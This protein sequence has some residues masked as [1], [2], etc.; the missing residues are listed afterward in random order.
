MNR[1][2]VLFF[3]IT[4]GIIFS[5]SA[6]KSFN[7]DD[8]LKNGNPENTDSVSTNISVFRY[9][10]YNSKDLEKFPNK[11]INSFI[12]TSA[13][14][15]ALN[16]SVGITE[17]MPLSVFGGRS[18]WNLYLIDGI[19]YNNP[20][21][22]QF[23][24]T[25][26]FSAIERVETSLGGFG[27]NYGNA[28][29]GVINIITKTGTDQFFGGGEVVSSSLT[30][31]YGF[32]FFNGYLGGPIIPGSKDYKFFLSVEKID[33]IDDNPRSI[34]LQ[35]PTANIDSEIL[36]SNESEVLRFTGKLNG[37]FGDFS[38]VFSAMGSFREARDYIHRY[39]K[40]NAIHNPRI[41]DEVVG[42]SLNINHDIDPTTK[43]GINFRYQSIYHQKGDG[44]WFDD[45]FAYG[46]SIKN[47]QIG[48]NL[49]LGD[50]S[51]FRTDTNGVFFDYGRV[52]DLY[53]KYKVNTIGCDLNFSK[54]INNLKLGFGGT[55]EQNTVRYYAINPIRIS[56]DKYNRSIEE[57]FYSS[58]WR[59]YGY[60]LTGEKEINSTSMRN[61]YNDEFEEAGAKKPLSASFYVDANYRLNR[62]RINAG[63]RYNYFDP[64][65]N[66]IKNPYKVLGD[67]GVLTEDD[68]EKAPTENY[69]S[70][71]LGMAFR[72]YNTTIFYS[73][74]GVY[75]KRPNLSSLYDSWNNI[76]DL[77]A[78]DGTGQKHGHLKSEKM[79]KF[80]IGINHSFCRKFDVELSY[81]YL[82]QMYLE[83]RSFQ[84]FIFGQGLTGYITNTNIDNGIVW[85]GPLVKLHYND[86]GF[87]DVNL[88]YA[89]IS[90]NSDDNSSTSSFVAAFRS[91]AI[92]QSIIISNLEKSLHVL[93]MNISI[94]FKKNEGPDLFEFKILE[95][96]NCNIIA[97]YISESNDFPA[98]ATNILA[99]STR[100]G[101]LTQYI[102]PN[103]RY[104]YC[105]VD[106]NI[107]RKIDIGGFNIIPYLWIQNLFNGQNYHTIYAST[108]KPD[109]SGFLSTTQGQ[110]EIAANGDSFASDYKALERNPSN[111]DIPRLIRLGLK[112]EF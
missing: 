99:G 56:F 89:Y 94:G 104:D 12:T 35:I 9:E 92:K 52:Y 31:D 103:K 63:L 11:G 18:Y 100:Y 62:L 60:D 6:N 13:G 26:P 96:T 102:N 59:Y 51:V 84:S 70:P 73:N 54:Q 95:N 106:L 14:V 71:R 17:N 85:D 105:K 32:N 27:A 88:N 79:Y 81:S 42:T 66:R 57:R 111:Y 53:E 101:S 38:T 78:G 82:N 86:F 49:P 33:V 98:S 90:T 69:F 77:E 41:K 74:F 20:F 8:K 22:G 97:S 75:W 48:V 93:N 91:Q 45:L 61:L 39:S 24:G 43:W 10:E 28:L 3:L 21:T 112:V 50:G 15:W 72:L 58:I 29:S 55:I 34:N 19:P 46:D 30:D 87:L 25:I 65:F 67:D 109:D 23:T 107:A 5:Q 40:N 36:P 1:N 16:G 83:V 37:R 68:F 4:T 64:N 44:V 76:D 7:E 108:G 110:Q 2:V 47:S 80:V